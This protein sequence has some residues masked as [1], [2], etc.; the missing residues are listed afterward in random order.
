V[1]QTR[2]YGNCGLL[3]WRE[4]TAP[5][6]RRVRRS[7][8]SAH[9]GVFGVLN[10]CLTFLK[11]PASTSNLR[12]LCT[13]KTQV[14]TGSKEVGKW[15]GEHPKSCA[16]ASSATPGEPPSHHP[17]ALIWRARRREV[18]IADVKVSNWETSVD[19]KRRTPSLPIHQ[20]WQARYERSWRMP[21]FSPRLPKFQFILFPMSC[22]NSLRFLP[23]SSTIRSR[24]SGVTSS[25]VMSAS[26]LHSPSL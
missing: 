18:C 23:H 10:L 15:L 25:K 19:S 24:S 14:L 8:K 4:V 16:S 20:M 21:L 1:P 7:P 2:R 26:Q 17:I 13:L 3:G 5:F 9:S 22:V 11:V 6:T 12:Q